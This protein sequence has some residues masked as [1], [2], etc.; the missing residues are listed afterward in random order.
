VAPVPRVRV[1]DLSLYYETHGVPDG[2][3]LV[4]L[5]GFMSTGA[6]WSEQLGALGERYRLVVPD[7][8][9][10]G[11][12]ANAA[13]L[14]AMTHRQFGRD[15][16]G[17]CRALG[18][19]R[20][21]FCGHSSGAMLLLT[22]GLEAPDLARAMILSGGTY[23]FA[24][25]L[26]AWWRTQTPETVAD[27]ARR[28]ALRAVHTAE[29]PDH[30]RTVVGAWLALADHA[31]GDDFP[32]QE[33]LRR[34]ETPVLLVHGDRDRFFP[35]E[36][37]ARLYGLLPDAELCLLPRTGHGPPRERAAWFNAIVLDFLA[38]RATGER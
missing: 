13:G 1:N 34:L 19:E 10:H 25:E 27:A 36:V 37:P 4:L 8:R 14:G 21:V 5:H 15:V 9:G 2:P 29:G 7:W 11:R 30:W 6:S 22:L 38:R 12:T 35:V 33:S 31:H 24:D 20:A 32:E 16:I 23:F 26:R 17:L 3:P 18:L 28:E